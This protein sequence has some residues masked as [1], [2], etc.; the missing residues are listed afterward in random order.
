MIQYSTLTNVTGSFP[1]YT[2]KNA[3]GAGATDGTPFV[4]AFIDDIWGRFQALMDRADLT[5]NA[6]TESASASQH[7][8][9]LKKG[10]ALGAGYVVQ[11]MKADSPA[12][13]GDRVLLLTGQGILRASY[14]ELDAAVYV[15]DANNAAVAA[16]G[17][18]FFRADN[19]DGSSPSTTGVYLIMPE[20]RGRVPRGDDAA[21]SVDPDGASRYLGDN[22]AD[23]FQGHKMGIEDGSGNVFVSTNQALTGS[24]DRVVGTGSPANSIRAA[25]F[26]TD[27]TNGTPRIDEETRMANFQTKWAITY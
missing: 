25:G 21:A 14:P 2:G 23:A 5:P 8:D 22:Q 9:S 19:S 16:A 10:F 15:G 3:T 24:T 11:Y 6:I 12:T 17:G 4:A 7:I 26:F 20:T 18:A 13:N 27:G 1:N